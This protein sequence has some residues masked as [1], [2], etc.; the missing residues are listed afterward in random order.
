MENARVAV[1]QAHGVRM[2]RRLSD[3]D[4]LGGRDRGLGESPE[5]REAQDEPATIVD[6]WRYGGTEILVDPLGGQGAQV[7]RGQLDDPFVVA[8]E[9]VSLLEIRRGQNA[10]SQIPEAP[11]DLQPAGAAL[12]SMVQLPEQRTEVG[13]DGADLAPPTII[14][15]PVGQGLGL[16]Q[17][18]Q[19]RAE[20]AD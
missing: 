2:L 20:L 10:E 18:L 11:G 13:R 17:A 7:A 8:P 3:A 15:Q 16:A 6:R 14:V 9:V 4:R 12:D 5:L 19:R 1:G